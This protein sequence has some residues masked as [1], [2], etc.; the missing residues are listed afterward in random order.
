MK[1]RIITP[2]TTQGFAT[3]DPFA[4]LVN[5]DTE[6]DMVQIETGPASIES[7]Y[8]EMLAVPGTVA[9][10]IEAERDGVDAVVINC[11]GDPGLH[12]SREAV[13][14][15]VV[16]PC[17]AT[18]HLASMLG[19]TFSVVT[20][21]SSL[22]P[23][24]ENQAKVYGVREKLASVRAV[25]ISVLDLE[26]DWDNMIASLTEQ[27]VLAVE[28]DGASVIMFGCTGMAGAAEAVEAGLVARGYDGVPVIDSMAAAIKVAEAIV[29]AKLT[30]SKRSFPY[31]P[32]KPVVGYDMPEIGNLAAVAD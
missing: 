28:E 1:V 16:G 22:R 29:G 7:A 23:Q 15:P 27:A 12:P 13:T 21:M 2:I 24:F 31:P 6:L 17:E 8:D 18:M 5:A 32:R 11:M 19:H 26:R 3:L 25:E 20:V 30:H 4:G 10:A 9:K 14:I